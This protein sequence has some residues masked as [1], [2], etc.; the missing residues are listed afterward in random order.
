MRILRREEVKKK[1][2]GILTLKSKFWTIL[3][4][5]CTHLDVFQAIPSPPR[6]WLSLL[7]Y[8]EHL[9]L[10]FFLSSLT[11]WPRQCSFDTHVPSRLC[12]S[13]PNSF[14]DLA[15][16]HLLTAPPGSKLVIVT[17]VSAGNHTCKFISSTLLPL[18]TSSTSCS[19]FFSF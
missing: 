15:S 18:L 17:D 11:L 13:S 4:T 1:K 8:G 19:V 7:V 2:P 3:I 5:F 9:Y 16:L 12:I 6:L 10:F 14:T